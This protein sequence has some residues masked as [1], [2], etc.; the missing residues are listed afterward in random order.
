MSGPPRLRV[1]SHRYHVQNQPGGQ[2]T[3]IDPRRRGPKLIG[4]IQ[5][6]IHLTGR[7]GGHRL[8]NGNPNSNL[9]Q[10]PVETG[11][12]S[13]CCSAHVPL[14]NFSVP[15]DLVGTLAPP[16]STGYQIHLPVR[17]G[18]GLLC[19]A[20]L[21]RAF[22]ITRARPTPLPLACCSLVQPAC[23][24]LAPLP[25]VPDWVLAPPPPL[26]LLVPTWYGPSPALL[27]RVRAFPALLVLTGYGPPPC[28][29]CP[30]RVRT[31]LLCL[32]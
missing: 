7:T 29:A 14:R 20:R 25:Y 5:I 10:R 21:N 8:P 3:T 16:P 4:Q 26:A 24:G 1:A 12:F 19:P 23:S 18:T 32:S 2:S 22:D 9:S 27:D 31:P 15:A 13:N 11:S 6:L 17:P 28:L 30:D